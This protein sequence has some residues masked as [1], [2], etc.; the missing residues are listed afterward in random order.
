MNKAERTS[1]PDSSSALPKQ[2]S[3]CVVVVVVGLLR[4]GLPAVTSVPVL[5]ANTMETCVSFRREKKKKKI[6]FNAIRNMGRTASRIDSNRD[7]RFHCQIRDNSMPP[8]QQLDWPAFAGLWDTMDSLP[9]FACLV[10]ARLKWF[11][12]VTVCREEWF[13]RNVLGATPFTQAAAFAG[14]KEAWA[15]PLGYL[16]ALAK[17]ARP[18]RT[19]HCSW[20]ARQGGVKATSLCRGDG[21]LGA[22]PVVSS[23][24]QAEETC[25][26]A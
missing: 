20:V 17:F 10:C 9:G 26:H 8:P 4:N 2:R 25:A 1:D 21:R 16:S 19:F 22:F 11:S 3:Q 6:A 12:K 14:R 24:P 13:L 5:N 15:R 23:G 18:Q 7:A